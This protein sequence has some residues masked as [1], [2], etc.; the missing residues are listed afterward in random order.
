MTTP[1]LAQLKTAIALS[2]DICTLVARRDQ[3]LEQVGAARAAEKDNESARSERFSFYHY[4][5][6]LAGAIETLARNDARALLIAQGQYDLLLSEMITPA[7]G[8]QTRRVNFHALPKKARPYLLAPFLGLM[9]GSAYPRLCLT[10]SRPEAGLLIYLSPGGP[11]DDAIWRQH[12]PM[13]SSWLGGEWTI[14]E[15]APSAITLK[16]RTPLAQN[17]PMHPGYLAPGSLFAG[18]D[19]AAHQPFSIPFADLTSG[20]FIP[21]ASGTGKSNALHILIQ[22]ILA[23]LNLF[24]AVY[25]IDGKD[26]VA[27]NRY[28]NHHPKVRVIWDEPDL[29]DLTEQLV[30]VMRERNRKQRDAHI[31]NATSRFI[32]V[33]I[34]EMSTYT[35]KPSIDNK[36]PDNKRHMA[37]I[38]NLGMLAKRGRST[39][40][41]LIIS[42][43]EPTSND[44]PANVRANCLT[45]LAFKL[46]LDAH[47]TAVF[48]QLDGLPADPRKLTRGQALFRNGLTGDIRAVQFPVLV[49]APQSRA[50]VVYDKYRRT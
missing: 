20:T 35:A 11:I 30:A 31:D 13:I 26:G 32:A 36:H 15:V 49:N 16:R 23:N 33:V 45:T 47:A 42:A 7:F 44:I 3:L 34:D 28:R 10:R 25:L 14:A 5:E 46:P 6:R 21:G 38:D 41:R 17:L 29:W 9:V 19:L 8:V 37:F 22:S 2:R 40:F 12:L 1:S 48:G 24:A 39:G 43:Q 27:F 50:L 4:P 18:I